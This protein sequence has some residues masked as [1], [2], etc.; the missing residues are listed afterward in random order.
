MA[1]NEVLRQ[2]L[3]DDPEGLGYATLSDPQAADLLN[4]ANRTVRGTA[5]ASDVRRFVLIKGLWPKI[6]VA[7]QSAPD[8]VVQGTAITILQTLAPHSFEQI[9]MS[10]TEVFDAVSQMLDVMVG[11]SIMTPEQKI[12]MIA[13]GDVVISRAE[14]LGL[15]YI[16]HIDVAEA[17]NG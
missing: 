14:Q 7:A 12:A 17:R 5:Q 6:A 10:D 8:P 3:T 4:T 16:H 1:V 9:R 15:G 11:A 13:L 2:E